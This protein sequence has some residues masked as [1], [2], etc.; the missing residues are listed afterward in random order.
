MYKGILI[1]LVLSFVMVIGLVPLYAYAEGTGGTKISEDVEIVNLLI[2][3]KPD[4]QK[5]GNI[6]ER[7]KAVAQEEKFKIKVEKGIPES[8]QI[9]NYYYIDDEVS[10]LYEENAKGS[11][12]IVFPTVKVKHE[13]QAKGKVTIAATGDLPDGIGGKASLTKNGNLLSSK[14]TTGLSSQMLVGDKLSS[15]IY[16]GFSGGKSTNSSTDVEADLGLQWSTAYSMDKWKPA[17]LI[18][19]NGTNNPDD[20]NY[21]AKMEFKSGYNQVQ[22]KNGFVPGS[23]VTMHVWRNYSDETVSNAI[24]LKHIGTANCA[25]MNCNDTTDTFLTSIA[26][27]PNANVSSVTS[28]KFLTTIAKSPKDTTTVV[29]GKAYGKFSNITLDG[30]YYTPTNP[31]EDYATVTFGTYSVAISVSKD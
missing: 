17:W 1:R 24:R 20:T 15:Y 13:K 23:D 25:D 6:L 12:M 22:Y 16:A 29:K 2:G 9:I 8:S 26:E 27:K 5:L 28:W 3:K 18:Y 30:T 21:G 11:K 14:V 7:A 10:Y 4:S 31:I 19:F